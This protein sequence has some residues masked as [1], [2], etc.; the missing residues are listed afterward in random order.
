MVLTPDPPD[1]H[2][3]R[4]AVQIQQDHPAWLII[5]GP[6]TRMYWAFARFTTPSAIIAAPGPRELTD[7]IRRVQLTAAHTLPTSSPTAKRS[8]DH[9]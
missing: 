2:Q 3:R 4:I 1:A 5:W 8:N 9:A 6:H 7:L